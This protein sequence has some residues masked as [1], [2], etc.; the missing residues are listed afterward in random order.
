SETNATAI[1]TAADTDNSVINDPSFYLNCQPSTSR[2]SKN[3]ETS[4]TTMPSD[5]SQIKNGSGTDNQNH[6]FFQ[7]NLTSNCNFG[8][9]C[10]PNNLEPDCNIFNQS[11]YNSLCF[12]GSTSVDCH[13]KLG[14]NF[15]N[16]SCLPTGVGSAGEVPLVLPEPYHNQGN[17][18]MPFMV[19]FFFITLVLSLILITVVIIIFRLVM[20]TELLFALEM[21]FAFFR[22]RR[23][24]TEMR[25]AVTRPL[26]FFSRV[27]SVYCV[28]PFQINLLSHAHLA[29]GGHQATLSIF[30]PAQRRPNPFLVQVNP[31]TTTKAVHLVNYVTH[32]IQ[33]QV[34]YFLHRL[35]WRQHSD[36]C[37]KFVKSV[38]IYFASP[39]FVSTIECI[40]IFVF[41]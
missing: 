33:L 1:A 5:N 3:V 12:S 29:P 35:N 19:L 16:C 40:S 7:P 26:T 37:S 31:R 8:C 17:A 6:T 24:I 22:F 21:Q 20:R 32:A 34:T 10:S 36:S 18:M 30:S 25:P 41:I 11:N 39:T 27:S 38:F 9:P 28:T 13:G 15:S 23:Y 14:Q 2:H 4:G